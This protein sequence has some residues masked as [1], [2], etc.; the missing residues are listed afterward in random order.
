MTSY[1]LRLTTQNGKNTNTNKRIQSDK[2][3]SSVVV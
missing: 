3:V 2:Q 1:I